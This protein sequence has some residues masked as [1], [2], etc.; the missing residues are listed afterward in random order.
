MSFRSGSPLQG[1]AWR[2]FCSGLSLGWMSVY[3]VLSLAGPPQFEEAGAATL[4]AR[5][6]SPIS[7]E[8]HIH[9]FMGSGLG[10]SDVDRD[11]Q[12]D[13][14]FCQGAPIETMKFGDATPALQ[15][16]RHDDRRFAEQSTAAQLTGTAY[17]NGLTIAD[18]DNDGFAD[19]FVTGLFSAALYRNNGDG[20][21]SDHTQPAGMAPHGFCTG[22]T[23]VDLDCDG[24]LDLICVRY[25]V[26]DR[27]RYP[28]CSV[29]YQGRAVAIS[30]NPRRF[31]GEADSVYRNRG[32]GTFDDV[33]ADWGFASAPPRQGLG[34]VA[35][36]VD[37]DGVVEAYVANDSSPNDLWA[38]TA[39]GRWHE[40]GLVAGVAVN[41]QGAAEAG[42]GIAA[43]DLDGD[44]RPELFVTNFF[45]ETNTL[46]RNEGDRAFL[47]VTEEFGVAGPSRQRLG[48]GVT[49]ADFDNDGWSDLLV[50]NGHVQ[51]QL[52]AVGIT[53]EPFAQLSQLLVNRAGRRFDDASSSSG[54]FF[55]R[56]TVARGT[57][58]ADVDGDG[59]V[60]VVV[61]RLN[62]RAAL[63]QNVTD[64]AGN[65][66][67]I[68]LLGT[69]SNRDGIGAT[70]IVR[71]GKQAW[72]RDRMASASYLS[73]DSPVLHI[74]LGEARVVDSVTVRWPSG[75]R[76][77]F[78]SVPVGRRSRLVEGAGVVLSP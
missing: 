68:E 4:S 77:R 31:P 10:W 40:C 70:V 61:L 39:P 49:L 52:A 42:M 15:F 74:G 75:V 3:A 73:C 50:A 6:V 2:I 18:L 57:A 78:S 38:R 28:L 71:S 23:W 66:I 67:A 7:A 48:F 43:G 45:N 17:A 64:R 63:L 51:D 47:D 13:L 56:P 8:R 9:L 32:D 58:A 33:T 34:C 65:W 54:P 53:N 29:N 46:Y 26:A 21:F 60:D 69:T 35:L 5:H 41:R 62:D 36:D 22:C 27:E 30:C 20:T 12:L 14:L 72:R 59:Q 24:Q 37:D 25:L 44:L 16:Y 19:V 55:L 11:G 1:C 76:E